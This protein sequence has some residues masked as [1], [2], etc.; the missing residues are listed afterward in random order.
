MRGVSDGQWNTQWE[1]TLKQMQGKVDMKR[2]E[3]KRKGRGRTGKGAD[4]RKGYE[5]KKARKLREAGQVKEGRL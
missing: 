1:A 2:R 3:E 5:G 4:G